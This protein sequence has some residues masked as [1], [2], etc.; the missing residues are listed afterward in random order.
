MGGKVRI[1]PVVSETA[2]H[3]DVGLKPWV[4]SDSG[5]W[6]CEKPARKSCKQPDHPKT[7]SV[8]HQRE[9]ATVMLHKNLRPMPDSYRLSVHLSILGT[10]PGT[11]IV[12]FSAEWSRVFV[13][14]LLLC[15]SVCLLRNTHAYSAIT[16]VMV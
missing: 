14:L 5:S 8:Y 4:E 15:Y 11:I 1:P 13:L 7:E 16:V 12:T 3:K 6:R 10:G 2:G 9:A